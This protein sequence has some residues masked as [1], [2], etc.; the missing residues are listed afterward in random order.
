MADALL[1]EIGSLVETTERSHVEVR[2]RWL[3][4]DGVL[5]LN[6]STRRRRSA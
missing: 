3:T 1:D 2:A 5:S 6:G 4:M